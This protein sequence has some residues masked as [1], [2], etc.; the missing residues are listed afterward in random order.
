MALSLQHLGGFMPCQFCIYERYPYMAA[1][2]IALIAIVVN[3]QSLDPAWMGVCF[4]CFLLGFGLSLYHIMIERHWLEMPSS[5]MVGTYEGS[6]FALKKGILKMHKLARCD[7]TSL[8]IL[9]LSLVEHNALLSF[10]MMCIS[11]AVGKELWEKST[12]ERS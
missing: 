10:S 6:F 11:G 2:I 8:K 7:Q 12:H 3:K 5:C 9:N 4:I 1:G